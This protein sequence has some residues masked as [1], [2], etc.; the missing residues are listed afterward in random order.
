MSSPSTSWLDFGRATCSDLSASESREWL[1]TNGLGSFAAGTVCGMLTRRYHGLLIAALDP[2]QARTLL[3]SKLEAVV[4]DGSS[5]YELGTNRWTGGTVAP[6]GYLHLERFHLEGTTPVW[7]YA[8]GEALLEKRVWM[9]PGAHTTYVQYTLRRAARPLHLSLKA[10][11]NYRDFH[12]ITHAG[13][14]SMHI[15]AVEHG[16]RVTAFDGAT[17]FS[18]LSPEAEVHHAHAWYKG[19]HLAAEAYR[20]LDAAEDHLHAGSFEQDLQ[21]GASMTV[22]LSTESAPSLDGATALGVRRHYEHT[23]QKQANLTDAPPEVQHLVLA[24]DQFV[25][26]RETPVSEDGKSVIAGYPWFGDW[27]RDTMIALPGLTLATGR[28]KVAA[29]ILRT[30]AHFVDQGMLPNRF[31]DV[32]EEP[33]YNTVDA[34]LWFIEAIRAYHKATG[35]DELL[36]DLFP[37]LRDIIDWHQRGTRYHI[38]VDTNDGLVYAGEPGVQLTWMD[39]KVGD[40]VVTPRIGKPVEINA[41]WYNALSSMAAFAKHLGEKGS[42]SFEKSAREVKRSFAQYWNDERGYCFDVIDGPHGNEASLRPNQLFAVS[43]AHSPLTKDQQKAVVD[44]CAAHLLSSHG[45]RSLAPSDPAFAGHYGGSPFERDGAY[46]QGTVWG[47]LIG[48]FAQAHQRVYKDPEVTRSFLFPLLRHLQ[49][50]CVGTMSEIF[51]GNAPFTPRGAIAQAWTVA[52]VLR[53]WHSTS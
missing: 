3:V 36:G 47:W 43:L 19:V 30:F 53:I 31:P 11:V 4:R 5:T 1:V 48:P 25:V 40:W 51:D 52:E 22:V 16:L 14:W 17:S 37:T 42:T 23:L 21:P 41:L 6:T 29:T 18:L 33:E 35:D 24:A 32:G 44:A 39:A 9:Q 10:L 2:P 7:T 50:A 38:Q 8:L 34:T 49:G 13:D 45:L 26:K 28:P 27:G 20:G 12:S 46:H 15:D